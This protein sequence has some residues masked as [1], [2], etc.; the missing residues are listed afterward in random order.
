M[1][2]RC[3][4]FPATWDQFHPWVTV[5]ND[6]PPPRWGVIPCID[7]YDPTGGPASQPRYVGMDPSD[8]A[9]WTR[10]YNPQ[11]GMIGYLPVD[12]AKVNPAQTGG[13]RKRWMR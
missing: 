2:V 1:P 3:R 9:T 6:A 5:S 11:P 8:P 10:P 7:F 4:Q 12:G 13:P